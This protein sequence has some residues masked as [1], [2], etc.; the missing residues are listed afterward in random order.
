M[1]QKDN[2]LS[3]MSRAVQHTPCHASGP[4]LRALCCSV[5]AMG[6]TGPFSTFPFAHRVAAHGTHEPVANIQQMQSPE[7][8]ESK[9]PCRKT[10]FC[11]SK[12]FPGPKI[13]RE[14]KRLYLQVSQTCGSPSVVPLLCSQAH[15]LRLVAEP[16]W[17]RGTFWGGAG[18]CLAL[19]YRDHDTAEVFA[20]LTLPFSVNVA[21]DS[22]QQIAN[23]SHWVTAQL[24][25]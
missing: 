4:C 23:K 9:H 16:H 2:L 3:K 6:L 5:G 22:W 13:S 21:A 11:L 24:P 19:L 20:G 12:R 7:R 10:S 17:D 25:A 15:S 1:S 18:L 8:Q 14:R